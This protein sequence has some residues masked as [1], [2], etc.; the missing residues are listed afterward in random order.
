MGTNSSFVSL[1]IV[2]YSLPSIQWIFQDHRGG[3]G[4]KEP[5][6][7]LGEIMILTLHYIS[8]HSVHAGCL[9]APLIVFGIIF[10]LAAKNTRDP[11]S[12]NN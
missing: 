10:I 9:E 4:L 2:F 3:K 11:S 8:K 5:Y 7:V 12:G 6:V 1:Y